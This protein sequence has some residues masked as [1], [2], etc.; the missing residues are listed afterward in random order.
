MSLH[1]EMR[2]DIPVFELSG[3]FDRDVSQALLRKI[4]DM[5]GIE[6]YVFFV[7]DM[8]LLTGIDS[9]GVGGLLSCHKLLE[10]NN[11]ALYIVGLRGAPRMVIQ[12]THIDHVL[13]LFDTMDDAFTYHDKAR[14]N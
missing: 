10:E 4:K 7:L 11:G 3:R 1:F 8:L 13:H 12:I 5:I 14:N 9:S 2:H 6:H